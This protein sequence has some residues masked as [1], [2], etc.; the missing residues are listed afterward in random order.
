MNKRIFISLFLL[1]AFLSLS[2]VSASDLNESQTLESNDV[3]IT[4]AQDSNVL[5]SQNEL[6][7]AFLMIDNDAG[8]E[9]V[10]VGELVTWTLTADNLGSDIAKNTKVYNQLPEGL[11]YLYHSSTKGVF[12]PQTGIWDIGDLKSEDG[13]VYLHITCKAITSGEKVNKAWITSDTK[14][15]NIKDYEEEEMDVLDYE[16][17][18]ENHDNIKNEVPILKSAGNPVFLI[19][20]CLFL[21]F[22]NVVVRR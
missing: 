5:S 3:E 2:A 11:Q 13:P 6:S 21:I 16:N 4:A 17:E 18:Y 9:N 10:Y 1:F 22:T 8:T 19:L 20:M 14:N 7:G 15:L 12:D